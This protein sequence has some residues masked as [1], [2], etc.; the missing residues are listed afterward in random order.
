MIIHI[1][2]QACCQIFHVNYE[3]LFATGP[4]SKG[5]NGHIF[6]SP[7]ITERKFAIY[8]I[9]SYVTQR[10]LNRFLNISTPMARAYIRCIEDL[11]EE[12]SRHAVIIEALEAKYAEIQA[13]RMGEVA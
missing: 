7:F 12:D 2:I 10:D 5:E 3:N 9:S 11:I 6:T 1:A 8:W 13:K 4:V